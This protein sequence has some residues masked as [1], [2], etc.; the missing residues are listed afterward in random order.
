MDDGAD[1]GVMCVLNGGAGAKEVVGEVAE[2]L[3]A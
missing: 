3:I 2:L 1:D